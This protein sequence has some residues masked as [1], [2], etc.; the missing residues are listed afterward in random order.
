MPSSAAVRIEHW[1]SFF[2]AAE[3]DIKGDALLDA[4]AGA[5]VP[6]RADRIDEAEPRGR[7]PVDIRAKRQRKR[8][9]LGSR[10]RRCRGGKRRVRP[11]HQQVRAGIATGD[12]CLGVA[13]A[14]VTI[15]YSSRSPTACSEVMTASGYHSI[16][17]HVD[18]MR[19]GPRP[20]DRAPPRPAPRWLAK[21]GSRGLASVDIVGL[22]KID[23]E[24]CARRGRYPS[25]S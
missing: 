7:G 3:S 22:P 16:R 2:G 17:S 23:G 14:A 8:S 11:Q 19:C 9:R 10:A 18:E 20:R 5:A 21:G 4:A 12:A 1:S 13:P 25:G 24:R 15:S 6:L